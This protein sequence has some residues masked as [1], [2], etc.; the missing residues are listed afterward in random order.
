MFNRRNLILG[1]SA[2]PLAAL[3]AFAGSKL[4][5][6]IFPVQNTEA[7]AIAFNVGTTWT[8][9][10]DISPVNACA[11]CSTRTFIVES[12]SSLAKNV[13]IRFCFRGNPLNG[14]NSAKVRL[15]SYYYDSNNVPQFDRT[16]PEVP[17]VPGY[18]ANTGA[19]ITTKFNGLF[20][21]P[22]GTQHSFFVEVWGAG[23]LFMARI[24]GSY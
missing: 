11:T 7:G 24:E 23:S 2:L 1:A 5:Y 18:L 21:S 22:V 4:D 8:R 10:M 20:S 15:V 12:D 14:T 16:W 17:N 3:P 6:D 9:T 19:N 13:Y